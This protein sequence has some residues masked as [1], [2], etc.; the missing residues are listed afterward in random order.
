MF[1]L[2]RCL[3]YLGL[4]T[5]I[6]VSNRWENK[7]E[8]L[9]GSY[10]FNSKNDFLCSDN[11]VDSDPVRYGLSW[12]ENGIPCDDDDAIITNACQVAS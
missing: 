9:C 2:C 7:L 11:A 4:L 8:G 10:D 1:I 12:K 6:Q 3:F 5:W